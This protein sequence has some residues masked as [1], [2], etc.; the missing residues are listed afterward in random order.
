MPIGIILN[1]I[2]VILGGIIGTVLRDKIPARLCR[3]LNLILGL[4]AM[5]MGISYIVQVET[6]PAVILALIIGTIFGEMISLE[7]R[8]SNVIGK[9]KTPISRLMGDGGNSSLPMD[10]FLSRYMCIVILFCASG[11]GIFGSI[12][13]G[14]TGEHTTLIVKAILDLCT[15][16]IFAT[17]LGIMVSLIAIP[18]FIIMI[19]LFLLAGFIY[20]LT[21][22]T[23][24]ADFTACGGILMIATGFRISEIENFPIANM[25]PA[26]I[27]VMPI[28][29]LWVQ[30]VLPLLA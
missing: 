24:I 4:S 26:M 23:M 13:S 5:S 14:M 9:I 29:Y 12:E 21:D 17:T 16:A 20:P 30:Y 7:E 6:L 22:A 28:S 10:E 25:I 27:I 11:T 8:L 2:A 3:T 1:C 19:T 18:Q 15:S